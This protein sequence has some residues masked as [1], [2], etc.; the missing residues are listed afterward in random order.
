MTLTYNPL[1]AMVITYS[2]EKIQGQ[3]QLD[4]K[5]EWKQTDEAD[6]ITSLAD[7]VCNNK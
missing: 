4:L 2:H 5:I 3:R 1:R 6:C 7:V